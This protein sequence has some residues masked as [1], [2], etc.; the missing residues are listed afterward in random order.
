MGSISYLIEA[1]LYF[2]HVTLTWNVY[3][4]TTDNYIP[5]ILS[6]RDACSSTL[7]LMSSL[8]EIT[9]TSLEIWGS[10]NDAFFTLQFTSDADADPIKEKVCV[11]KVSKIHRILACT[12]T[13]MMQV[14]WLFWADALYV[15][16]SLLYCGYSYVKYSSHLSR[17]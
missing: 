9:G 5:L 6:C 3:V 8:C 14:Y 16:G 15:L 17:V 13:A 10:K 2:H 1:Y 7:L 4:R 12:L 11:K